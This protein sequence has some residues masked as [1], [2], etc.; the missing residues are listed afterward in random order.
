MTQKIAVNKQHGGYG[1]SVEFWERY[2]ELKGFVLVKTNG[3]FKG[4]YNFYKDSEAEENR[5]DE[6]AIPRDDPTLIQIIEELGSDRVSGPFAHI[7]IVEIPDDVNWFVE[8]YD[9]SEWVAERH[10]KWY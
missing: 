9:G 3:W 5:L 6:D 2:A 8:E 7:E 4:V 10:R 1:L